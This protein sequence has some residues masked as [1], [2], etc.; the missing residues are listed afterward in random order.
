MQIQKEKVRI[1][2]KRL[3]L[4]IE[5]K[6]LYPEGDYD[7]DIVF[8]SKEVRKARKQMGKRHDPGNRI[9]IPGRNNLEC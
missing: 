6:E 3:S 5:R 7:M 1:N 8:E 4:Y 9:I 2:R